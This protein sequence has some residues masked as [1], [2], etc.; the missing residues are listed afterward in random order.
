MEQ[1]RCMSEDGI[2]ELF[3]RKY[4]HPLIVSIPISAQATRF[5]MKLRPFYVYA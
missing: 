2:A 4:V 1:L 5:M 3:Q